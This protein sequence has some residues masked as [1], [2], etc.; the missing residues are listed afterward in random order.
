M[1]E[2]VGLT[3]QRKTETFILDSIISC[4]EDRNTE[5]K[6]V[7]VAKKLIEYILKLAT[8]YMNAFLNTDGGSIYFGVE[9]DGAIKG[10]ELNRKDRDQLRQG[11][12]QIINRY[13][14][15]VDP[16]LYRLDFI[17]VIDP[18]SE[19]QNL[20]LCV[21][22]ITVQ[23]GTAPVYFVGGG[24]FSA[25]LRRDGGTKK[26]EP[27]LIEERLRIAS[28][29]QNMTEMFAYNVAE[30]YTSFQQQFNDAD[31]W[32]DGDGEYDANPNTPEIGSPSSFSLADV[33]QSAG[34]SRMMG[35]VPLSSASASA[36]SSFAPPVASSYS[37]SGISPSMLNMTSSSFSAHTMFHQ[38]R[39]REFIGRQ[40]E[41][42]L[43]SAFI[44]QTAGECRVITIFGGLAMGKSALARQLFF[45][46]GGKDPSRGIIIDLK[47]GE[48]GKKTSPV[49][50]M[51][52]VIVERIEGVAALTQC[53]DSY[54]KSLYQSLFNQQASPHNHT[55]FSAQSRSPS[56]SSLSSLTSP[57][58]P[59]SLPPSLPLPLP[60]PPLPQTS[61]FV[62]PSSPRDSLSFGPIPL[63]AQSS[64]TTNAPSSQNNLS[65]ALNLS[66]IHLPPPPSHTSASPMPIPLPLSQSS[67]PQSHSYHPSSSSNSSFHMS[68]NSSSSELQSNTSNTQINQI[69]SNSA[70]SSQHTQ[71]TP[72]VTPPLPPSSSLSP[73]L[74]PLSLSPTVRTRKQQMLPSFLTSPVVCAQNTTP[75]ASQTQP[76][77]QLS[78]SA[79]PSLHLRE[80][81]QLQ[82]KV[83]H[84]THNSSL[85]PPPPLSPSC[86]HPSNEPFALD[87]NS[88]QQ[89]Q[90]SQQSQQQQQQLQQHIHSLPHSLSLSPRHSMLSLSLEPLSPLPS[91]SFFPSSISPSSS[92]SSSSKRTRS[93]SASSS[94][95]PSAS[96]SSSCSSS[97]GSSSN[98]FSASPVSSVR[99]L[100]RPTSPTPT[101]TTPTS[102]SIGHSLLPSHVL[103]I[104]NASHFEQIH[105]LIPKQ[106]D[107]VVFVTSHRHI[108]IDTPIRLY[109]MRL[110]PLKRSDS[111]SL[112]TSSMDLSHSPI[113]R[114]EADMLAAVCGDLPHSLI[115]AAALLRRR[116]NLSVESLCSQL[117]AHSRVPLHISSFRALL[118]GASEKMPLKEEPLRDLMCLA[119][120]RGSFRMDEA[121]VLLRKNE[122]WTS[123]IIGYLHEH[124]LVEFEPMTRRCH[125]NTLVRSYLLREAQE[126]EGVLEDIMS[127]FITCYT[128]YLRAI[129][130]GTVKEKEKEKERERE[131]R[132]QWVEMQTAGDSATEKGGESQTGGDTP[133]S[134]LASP[135][136]QSA[137]VSSSSPSTP[138]E[139][140]SPSPLAA[141]ASASSS[142]SSSSSQPPHS[143]SASTPSHQFAST[144]SMKREKKIALLEAD[145]HNFEEVVTRL[146]KGYAPYFRP[147]YKKLQVV[148]ALLEPFADVLRPC[149]VES[150]KLFFKSSSSQNDQSSVAPSMS[151]PPPPSMLLMRSRHKNE[152]HTDDLSFSNYTEDLTGPGT[153]KV[154]LPSGFCS[155]AES[156]S[157]DGGGKE[158]SSCEEE[159]ADSDSCTAC[160]S[161]SYSDA[162]SS[163]DDN[164][165]HDDEE[166]DEDEERAKDED[167]NE[168]Q[169]KRVAIPRPAQPKVFAAPAQRNAKAGKKRKENQNIP[170]NA[171]AD[172]KNPSSKW[173]WRKAK[174]TSS[175]RPKRKD[176]ISGTL[177][178]PIPIFQES[179]SSKTFSEGGLSF[180]DY[181]RTAPSHERF[182]ARSVS[183]STSVF[184]SSISPSSLSP[185]FYSSYMKYPSTSSS[186]DSSSSFSSSSSSSSSVP[187]SDYQPP[188][189]SCSVDSSFLPSVQNA[190]ISD[191]LSS[192]ASG[193]HNVF[194]VTAVHPLS[195]QKAS[196]GSSSSLSS[197]VSAEEP[198]SSPSPSPSHSPSP[199]VSSQH[200]PTPVVPALS[201]TSPIQ[202]AS[203]A[204]LPSQGSNREAERQGS[205]HEGSKRGQSKQSM[206]SR[207]KEKALERIRKLI[208][209]R[210]EVNSKRMRYEKEREETE[211]DG[212]KSKQKERSKKADPFHYLGQLKERKKGKRSSEDPRSEEA[213]EAIARKYSTESVPSKYASSATSLDG[214]ANTDSESNAPQTNEPKMHEKDALELAP[215]SRFDD[216]A[217]GAAPIIIPKH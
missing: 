52:A 14:P 122:E 143:P 140:A 7:Q 1:E 133:A 37:S 123:Q 57:A 81:I 176:S 129:V 216:S 99:V 202:K 53:A 64:N 113:T 24:K 91:S 30:P 137:S 170:A 141:S 18:K 32:K 182:S 150:I 2:N 189:V 172:D 199:A 74:H 69:D 82:L 27:S 132:R 210:E 33:A 79:E 197:S 209:L 194:S 190:L 118:S 80:A 75:G 60:P 85:P 62:C 54:V 148:A 204:S 156:H 127:R 126:R 116:P 162:D 191:Q 16:S 173:K 63:N 19:H 39:P 10:I 195:P 117:A 45:L 109:E 145:M 68:E 49:D 5:F 212:R 203:F 47:S 71:F 107:T 166:D 144:P 131:E 149:V 119:P 21:V 70:V 78:S 90:Q 59:L 175:R 201:R 23:K 108:H 153:S 198:A 120:C 181:D 46:F 98:A 188:F 177:P 139:L 104:E 130:N 103:L 96:S 31:N 167:G 38:S 112:L 174:G 159:D 41:I 206:N 180:Y 196:A 135:S 13:R 147:S 43:I 215:S 178:P 165:D 213:Y 128:N 154:Q 55:P 151:P 124:S 193:I 208:R 157:E 183:P 110:A 6:A 26:M 93:I 205:A 40:M 15:Q 29:E 9:D 94:S 12:D 160:V 61:S 134:Q 95:S 51:R 121:E 200:I 115:S 28:Y 66:H 34:Q 114:Q 44:S 211:K 58:L 187:P 152:A 88:N 92:D 164:D 217:V 83:P 20:N 169:T 65:G 35:L 76:N 73:S 207:L 42:K 11:I 168:V 163:E 105:P 4:E 86:V 17:S 185:S 97:N 106:S 77:S 3:T 36:S 161:T 214:A 22:R 84:L 100:S 102:S 89:S 186:S 158:N 56:S 179:T 101:P 67:S 87:S 111:I 138:A 48:D 25:Y 192:A 155:I 142:S 72:P 50:A 171:D 136:S 146:E 8:E 184:S 125:V